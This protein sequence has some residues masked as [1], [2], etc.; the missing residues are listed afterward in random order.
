MM[1]DVSRSE[2][3]AFLSS[4]RRR[5][6]PTDVGLAG[7]TRRRADG[8]RREEVAQLAAISVD[9]YARLEQGRSAAPSPP[10]LELLARTLQLTADERHHLFTLAGAALPPRLAMTSE[11]ARGTVHLVQ[12][13]S[14]VPVLVIDAKYDVLAWNRLAASLFHDFSQWAPPTRN[15]IW[16]VFCDPSTRALYIDDDAQW[17]ARTAVAD[18]RS[19]AGRYPHDE[20]I[21]AL[22]ADLTARSPEFVELWNENEVEQQ[23]S[24]AKRLHHRSVGSLEL[25]LEVLSI[26]D[27]DQRVLIYTASPGSR[28]HEA[29]RLL[30]VVGTQDVVTDAARVDGGSWP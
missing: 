15:F 4:R 17:F 3:G 14:D 1:R 8:L 16:R 6:Q 28:S 7:G 21:A 13:L 18:L 12:H 5:L 2:L 30:A 26:P 10:V 20:G 25:E 11:V 27:R 23:R 24:T 29:L 9:Y 22:V 19:A